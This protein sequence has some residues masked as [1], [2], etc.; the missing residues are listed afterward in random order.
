MK[1]LIELAREVLADCGDL[2]GTDT[3]L[4]ISYVEGRHEHEGLEFLT[5]ALPTYGKD[6]ETSLDRGYV[7]PDLFLGY[8]RL[9]AGAK[10]GKLPAF[11]GGFMRLVFDGTTGL[12]LDVPRTDAI[13]AI[14]QFTLMWTKIEIQCTPEREAEA[15]RQYIGCEKELGSSEISL[16]TFGKGLTYQGFDRRLSPRA[17]SLFSEFQVISEKLFGSVLRKLNHDVLDTNIIPKH[18]P[19]ATADKLVGNNK[20]NQLEWTERLEEY[21]PHGIYLASRWGYY[22][23]LDHVQ[24]LEPGAER[25]VKVTLVPKTQ[26]TPRIIAIEPTCMQY[27]QQGLM[28]KF[29][30]YLEGFDSPRGFIGFTDQTPNQEL[31]WDGSLHGD[32]ATLDLSEASDRVHYLL[33]RTMLLNHPDLSGAIDACRSRTAELPDGEVVTLSKFASMGSALCFPIEAMVF[34]TLVFVG[35]QREL[36]RPLTDKDFDSFVGKVRVYG[37]DIIVPT[38]Y[39]QSVIETLEAFGLLVNRHKSFWTGRFRE[40]CGKEFYDGCDVSI[41][42]VRRELP[43]SQKNVQEII[44]AVSLRNQLYKAGFW[45]SARYLDQLIERFI[46]FPTVLE[47]SPVLGKHSFLGY[48]QERMCPRLHRPLV[49]GYVVVDKIPNNPLDGFAALLKCFLK[50]GLEPFADKEHLRRSGRPVAVNMKLRWAPAV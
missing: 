40:S 11:L 42:K 32:L 30:E 20:Y 36:N 47:T 31:A 12:L 18:G 4:D 10:A 27:V 21:F 5:L 8:K 16:E 9:R 34:T 3:T 45:K 25:P 37:D 13:F 1:D 39:V 50:R 14:R 2:C 49:R 29:V 6:L 17:G 48:Y 28:E 41:T 23:D 19:G 26:K 35:I 38:D 22:P 33:V 24:L 46:P 7:G 43:T 44:S 15:I